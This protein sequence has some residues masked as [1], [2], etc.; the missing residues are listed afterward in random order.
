VK[1]F[2]GSSSFPASAVECTTR[3]VARLTDGRVPYAYTTEIEGRGQFIADGPQSLSALQLQAEVA[4]SQFGLDFLMLDDSG[5]ATS[6]R[7]LSKGAEFPGVVVEGFEFPE[8]RLGDMATG[9]EFRFRATATYPTLRAFGAILRYQEKVGVRGNGGPRI[10][11]QEAVNGPPMPVQLSP[12]TLTT[13]IQTGSAV[14]YI[15]YPTP[16]PPILSTAYLVNPDQAVERLSPRPNG[17]EYGIAWNYVFRFPGR[18]PRPPLP[19]VYI[20]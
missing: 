4:F 15:A 7:L 3:T 8:S 14:G 11:W 19:N 18:L 20:G 10:N 13:V 12:V 2:Y 6:I 9:R 1:L 17:T 5:A 16:P